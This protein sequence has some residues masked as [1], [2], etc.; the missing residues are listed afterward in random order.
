MGCDFK[1]TLLAKKGG[2]PQIKTIN[3]IIRLCVS[4][5][6]C[7]VIS[8]CSIFIHHPHLVFLAEFTQQSV[9][10]WSRLSVLGHRGSGQR[11]EHLN[12]PRPLL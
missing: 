12:E 4:F 8:C 7:A 11:V 2:C 6:R 9:F 5:Y 1:T 10:C 3:L